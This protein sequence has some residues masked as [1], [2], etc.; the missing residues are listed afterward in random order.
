MVKQQQDERPISQ[1]CSHR[2]G[3][4]RGKPSRGEADGQL[5]HQSV[6]S[7]SFQAD[8]SGATRV[9]SGQFIPSSSS[10]T[11]SQSEIFSEQNYCC[12]SHSRTT[13]PSQSE[14]LRFLQ[15]IST[16][17]HRITRKLTTS[18]LR[19]TSSVIK[20]HRTL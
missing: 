20:T 8:S 15:N 6:K 7:H 16:T 11:P 2:R 5:N 4:H 10:H 1:P 12:S 3:C 14:I 18:T 9:Q 19:A 13:T 17:S